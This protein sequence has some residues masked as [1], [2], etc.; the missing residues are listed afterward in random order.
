MNGWRALTHRNYLDHSSF[1]STSPGGVV[2]LW[3]KLVKAGMMGRGMR[4]ECVLDL[5]CEGKTSLG[6][7]LELKL[8]CAL[9]LLRSQ[10]TIQK[11]GWGLACGDVRLKMTVGHSH[12]LSH[13]GIPLRLLLTGQARGL[14]SSSK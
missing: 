13:L 3:Q 10:A 12:T 1:T 2:N 7:G 11:D 6:R 9:S 4:P 14:W 5:S 8:G